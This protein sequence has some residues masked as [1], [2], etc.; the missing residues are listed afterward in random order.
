MTGSNFSPSALT[1]TEQSNVASISCHNCI[2]LLNQRFIGECFTK[3]RSFVTVKNILQFVTFDHIL[4]AFTPRPTTP[5]ST[6]P[7][8][9]E[10]ASSPILYLIFH[11]SSQPLYALKFVMFKDFAISVV[12]SCIMGS[13]VMGP[14]TVTLDSQTI[15]NHLK[16]ILLISSNSD[17][18][19]RF[20][21]FG[22]TLFAHSCNF[23]IS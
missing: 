6:S 17:G 13:V 18:L 15:Q 5:S 12:S 2:L 8:S 10:T 14:L 16:T 1:K 11:F 21:S 19:P 4:Q 20:L 22:L 9:P 3:K 7:S 23:R